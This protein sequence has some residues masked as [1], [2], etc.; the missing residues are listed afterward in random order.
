MLLVSWSGRYYNTFILIFR[1]VKIK[2]LYSCVLSRFDLS[3][4]S[5]NDKYCTC[6]YTSSLEPTLVRSVS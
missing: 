6:L 1:L 5:R 2:W 4:P 3:W